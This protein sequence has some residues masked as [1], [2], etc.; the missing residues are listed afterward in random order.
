MAR[1]IA[2]RLDIKEVARD[3]SEAR[4]EL[5]VNN[6]LCDNKPQD[7][8]VI[9]VAG[10]D[11]P[12]NQ[13]NFGIIFISKFV[14]GPWA[15]PLREDD[16]ALKLKGWLEINDVVK[17]EWVSMEDTT[18]ITLNGTERQKHE[19]RFFRVVDEAGMMSLLN[20]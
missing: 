13:G 14:E 8:G 3:T 4:Y 11:W 19:Y 15:G 10:I 5:H 12:P 16:Q 18:S 17:P 9:K 1:T 6:W 2:A 7:I 20:S